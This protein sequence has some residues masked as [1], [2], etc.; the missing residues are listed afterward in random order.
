M[1]QACIHVHAYTCK[2]STCLAYV[3]I[4]KEAVRPEANQDHMYSTCMTL[5]KDVVLDRLESDI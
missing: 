4:V 3:G 1:H 5:C 2:Y